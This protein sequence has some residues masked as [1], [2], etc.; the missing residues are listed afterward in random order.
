MIEESEARSRILA[1]VPESCAEVLPLAESLGRYAAGEMLA[2]VALPGFDNSAMDGYAVLAAEATAGAS[3]QLAGEQ[4]AGKDLGLVL[5]GG[6]AIRIFTGAPMPKGANAVVMQEDV[7]R[8]GDLVVIREASEVGEFVRFRGSDL[9]EGQRIIAKRDRIS[10]QRI[11][12]LASQG[13]GELS[14]GKL[15]SVGIL[16][17]GDELKVSGSELSAGEIFNSNGP[18]LAA[19]VRRIHPAIRVTAYHGADEEVALR[20]V[21]GRALAECDVLV[22]A[23]GVS[24]GDRDLVKPVLESCGVEMDFWKVK[25]KP[26]KPFVFGRGDRTLVFGLPGNPV[27]AFVTF[28]V[29]VAPA[30]RRW[31]GA[32]EDEVLPVASEVELG[33]AVANRGDRPHYVRGTFEA[34]TG[35]F[36]P[37][38]MQQSH[39]LN[40]LAQADGLLRMEAEESLEAGAVVR[41]F[42]VA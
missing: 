39:A 1:G 40:G 23:G 28:E 9:C 15:P 17:T 22:V 36:F 11:G 31:M 14:V 8:D 7:D 29:F 12:L 3:L 27:S 16:T 32:R 24:V 41:V 35:K 4:P 38:G 20:E 25:L 19:M 21:V 30:L 18:M 42:P 5:G 33:A 26:G 10:A 37:I 13:I 34:A 2:E 6:E